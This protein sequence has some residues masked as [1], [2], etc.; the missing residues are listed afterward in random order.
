MQP[1]EFF[2]RAAART[3]NEVAVYT[4]DRR[5]T[6]GE[7]A[8]QVMSLA[9]YLKAEDPRPQT[10][11]CVG[12][13]NSIEHLVAILAVI[14]AG[15]VWVA[16]NPRNGDPE[17]QRMVEYIEPSALLLD[18]AMAVRVAG[19]KLP[20]YMLDGPAGDTVFRRAGNQE[21][22]FTRTYLPLDATTAIKFTGGTSGVP[23][24]VMQ[25][26]R[27]WNANIVSQRHAYGFTAKDRYL[28]N[29]PLTHGASTYI[30]PILGAGG[31][32][33]FP[34]D[35]KPAALLRAI[36]EH[37]VTT[38][39]SPPT[40]V[41][42]LV[43][44][45]RSENVATPSLRN[46]IYGGAPMRPARIR[47]AQE[48]FGPVIAATYGQT[49]APQIITQLSAQELM[50]EENLA[51]AGRP[52]LMTDVGIM[53]TAGNLLPAGQQGEIVARGDLVMTG[54]FNMPDKT[55]E[56]IVDGWLHT[57]DLGVF[58]ERGY[59][60]LRDRL[61]EVIITGGFNVYPSDVETVISQHPAVAECAVIGIPDDHW[62]EAVHAAVEA[63]PGF[64]VRPEEVIA[65]VKG[66]LGSVKTPKSVHVFSSMPK[67]AV[68]KILKTA[69]R[70]QILAGSKVE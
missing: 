1:I 46:I 67:S 31:A 6:F 19:H 61:R 30:L 28:V 50:R 33:V 42:M 9:A 41:A 16:L 68:G 4:P 52:S 55:A 44:A 10:R 17:L 32:F 45:A 35:T 70:D 40:M 59:L 2:F 3:P 23:K 39:F 34:E 7:L 66:Q 24:G 12:C 15:K 22:R 13:K 26:Y 27:G 37:E 56:T 53:D 11:V 14:A 25:P 63:K 21:A 62:G 48:A 36:A 54:Y 64:D 58:D 8:S 65:F 38:F 69:L 20:V 43:D 51:S 47:E 57:G 5:V 49:E 29:A 60:F 18:E